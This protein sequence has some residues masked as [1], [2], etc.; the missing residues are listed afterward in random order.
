MTRNIAAMVIADIIMRNLNALVVAVG[1]TN[2]HETVITIAA[3]LAVAQWTPMGHIVLTSVMTLNTAALAV[4]ANAA[5]G[6][7]QVIIAI[8]LTD[9]AKITEIDAAEPALST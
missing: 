8:D 7:M 3:D 5:A 9:S 4:P 1:T 2:I 6:T